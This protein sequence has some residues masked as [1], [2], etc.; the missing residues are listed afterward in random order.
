MGKAE[1]QGSAS[2]QQCLSCGYSAAFLGE[3]EGKEGTE[4]T[5][6]AFSDL[7][8]P[9]HLNQPADEMKVGMP[10]GQLEVIF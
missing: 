5:A 9:D 1:Y 10:D 3:T 6:L 2:K 4:C 7:I 8:L